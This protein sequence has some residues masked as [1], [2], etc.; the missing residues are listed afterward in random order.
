MTTR[1]FSVNSSDGV[2][3]YAVAVQWDGNNLYVACDCKAGSLG[4]WCRHKS[5]ILN[6]EEDIL[7]VKE[8]LTDVLQ[9]VKSS[10]VHAAMSDIQNFEIQQKEAEASLKK[11]KARVQAAKRAAAVLVSPH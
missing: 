8:D 9:W 10:P 7:A 2:A 3:T 4:D 1:V 11:V 6:G 5:A